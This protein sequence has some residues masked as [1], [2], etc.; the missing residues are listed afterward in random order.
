MKMTVFVAKIIAIQEKSSEKY[1]YLGLVPH[2]TGMS[3]IAST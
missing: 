3:I 1:R 2:F